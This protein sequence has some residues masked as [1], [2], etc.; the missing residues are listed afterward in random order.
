MGLSQCNQYCDSITLPEE[1]QMPT[2]ELLL[3]LF[4]TNCAAGSVASL[5]VEKWLVGIHCGHQIADALW[6]GHQFLLQKKKGAVRLVPAA[7]QHARHFPNTLRHLDALCRCL[8]LSSLFDAAVY[9]VA[10]IA[11]WACCCLGKLL[12][13][14]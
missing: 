5:T 9:A 2:S 4:V 13:I 3:A 6:L 7:S 8:C 11:F 12:I 14:S 10:C 1:G